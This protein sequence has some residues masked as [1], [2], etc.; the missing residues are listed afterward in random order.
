MSL[1]RVVW[2]AYSLKTPSATNR[3]IMGGQPKDHGT[4]NGVTTLCGMTN[5]GENRDVAFNP[6]GAYSCKRC[7]RKVA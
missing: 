7:A 2:L 4:D 3:G 6:E 5:I 1:T